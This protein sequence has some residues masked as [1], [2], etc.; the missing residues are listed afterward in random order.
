MQAEKGASLRLAEFAANLQYEDL[1]PNAIEQVKFCI[2]D[3][4]GVSF[5]GSQKAAAQIMQKTVRELLGEDYRDGTSTLWQP[6][7]PKTNAAQAALL[8]GT[9][10]HAI[11][12]DDL[13]N[14]SIIHL[15]VVTV[16]T[17][18]AL[19]EML[20][21]SGKEIITAVAAGYEV[22]ARI[23]EAVNPSSYWFWHTTGTVGNFSAAA[24]TGRLLE[25]TPEQLNHAFGQAGSQAAGLW[26]FM[27]DGA[28]SKTLHTGKANYN[29]ILAAYLAKGGFTGASAILEGAKGFVRA[30]APE[31]DLDALT[32]DLAKAGQPGYPYRVETNSFKPYACC[33]HIHSGIY[34]VQQAV[35]KH[36]LTPAMV[37]KIHDRT[38][39]TAVELTDNPTPASLY[40]H[41][42]SIQYCL[43]AALCYG[44]VP[45]AVFSEDKVYA[46]QVRELM[47]NVQVSVDPALQA[48]FAEDNSKWLHEVDF[49]LQDGRKLTERVEYPFGDFRNPFACTAADNKF[50][51]LTADL[52]T[53]K[54][55]ERLLA[56]LHNL[57]DLPDASELFS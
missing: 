50:R 11:D 34:A 53:A 33:R 6:G 12:M 31:A 20:G 36:G 44:D 22:G 51:M 30:V 47:Q 26:E 4:I 21:S 15:A 2:E 10:G 16:P 43:A 35:K 49:Y 23:G 38:Y 7:L 25:L 37:Q 8:N 32:V 19:G 48:E 24:V 17:A 13:H 52:L 41:K 9:A 54:Q 46:P 27:Y 28:M 56:K 42:F 5:A 18:L 39:K 1:T 45:D 40:G 55:Q 3:I 29:G 14:S 57:E